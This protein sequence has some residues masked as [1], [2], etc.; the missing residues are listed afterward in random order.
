METCFGV[1][2]MFYTCMFF[3]IS[4]LTIRAELKVFVTGE[5]RLFSKFSKLQMCYC[6]VAESHLCSS[7]ILT[8]Q[9]ESNSFTDDLNAPLLH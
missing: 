7:Q 3:I 1:F 8:E 4:L 5:P 6:V 2:I 9:L